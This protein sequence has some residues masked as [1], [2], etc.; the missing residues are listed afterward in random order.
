MIHTTVGSK[1][2]LYQIENY[3]MLFII[4][5]ARDIGLHSSV[6]NCKFRFRFIDND[7]ATHRCNLRG[8]NEKLIEI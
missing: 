1:N 8:G 5:Y 3:F 4:V 6:S 7:V 2:R